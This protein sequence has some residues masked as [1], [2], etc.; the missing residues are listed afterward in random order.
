MLKVIDIQGMQ[1][2]VFYSDIGQYTTSFVLVIFRNN[3]KHTINKTHELFHASLN[4]FAPVPE[5]N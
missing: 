3:I 2:E 5:S 1:S 4:P